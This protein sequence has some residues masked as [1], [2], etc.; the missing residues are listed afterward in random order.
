MGKGSLPVTESAAD[1]ILSLP[2]FPELS[3]AQIDRVADAI[4]DFYRS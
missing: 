1:S 3:E 2:M 4:R